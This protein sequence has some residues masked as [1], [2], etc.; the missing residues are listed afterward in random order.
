MSADARFMDAALALG[1]RN[2]GLTAPNP[3][4]GALIVLGERVVGARRHRAGRAAACGDDRARR[5]GRAGEAARPLYVTLEPCAHH[6]ATPP[7]AEALVAAGVGRVVCALEDPDARVAGQGH[8]AAARG[9]D[10]RR[11]RPRRGRRRGA[12]ISATSCA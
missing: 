9:G 12:I 10:R 4:V 3:S 2:L 5:S 11:G 7:C 1:R 6:G 8:R